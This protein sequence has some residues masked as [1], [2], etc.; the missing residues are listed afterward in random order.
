MTWSIVAVS[1]LITF[2][3][4]GI[5]TGLSLTDARADHVTLAGIG[6]SPRLRK[7]LAGSQALLTGGLG[8]LLGS[9]AGT[10]PAVLVAGSTELRTA[11]EVP[12]LHLLAL[13]VAV[14]LAGAL[15]AWLFTRARLP[16]S[17]RTLG[18]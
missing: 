4:A 10:L 7:S 8:T 17:R 3:A 15:L 9:L 16:S 11:V 12:W 14:P 1:A 5:T 2:S 13:V 18:T 6:A